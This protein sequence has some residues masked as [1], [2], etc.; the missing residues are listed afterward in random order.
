MGKTKKL[1]CVI[2]DFFQQFRRLLTQRM[3]D[4]NCEFQ[5][6]FK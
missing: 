4:H 1:F 2:D 3:V 6:R 5:W